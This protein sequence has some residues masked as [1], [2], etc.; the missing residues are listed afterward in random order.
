LQLTDLLWH[1]APGESNAAI[2]TPGVLGSRWNRLSQTAACEPQTVLCPSGLS[3]SAVPVKLGNRLIGFLRTGAE[4]ASNRNS[5]SVPSGSAKSIESLGFTDKRPAVN[6]SRTR[7]NMLCWQ[8][9]TTVAKRIAFAGFR[10]AESGGGETS[11]AQLTEA[12][13]L[14]ASITSV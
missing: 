1:G 2:I 14:S 3:D 5:H 11:A 9:G 7:I 13:I 8:V 6:N 4:S 10:A 12:L